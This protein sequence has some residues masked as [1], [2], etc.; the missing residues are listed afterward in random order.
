MIDC[1]QIRY[2]MEEYIIFNL[3]LLNLFALY[4]HAV[5]LKNSYERHLKNSVRGVNVSQAR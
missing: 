5:N 3:L 1:V 2:E 4:A